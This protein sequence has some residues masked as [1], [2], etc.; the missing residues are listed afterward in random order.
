MTEKNLGM[1]KIYPKKGDS[2]L[3]GKLVWKSGRKAVPTNQNQSSCCFGVSLIFTS[4]KLI[5][6]MP[7]PTNE[8]YKST[9]HTVHWTF[10]WMSNWSWACHFTMKKEMS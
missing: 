7:F 5:F 9:T 6:T 8:T 4:T 10:S 3:E 1:T 2:C